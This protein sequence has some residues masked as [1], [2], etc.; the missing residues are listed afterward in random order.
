MGCRSAGSSAGP[1]PLGSPCLPAGEA[2]ALPRGRAR[3]GAASRP[4]GS[5]A[6]AGES[7]AAAVVAAAVGSGQGVAGGGPGAAPRAMTGGTV[8]RIWNES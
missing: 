8:A 2:A 1:G 4:S 3:G 6:R 5:G 7:P